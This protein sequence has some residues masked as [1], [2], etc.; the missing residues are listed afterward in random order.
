MSTDICVYVIGSNK[1][2]SAITNAHDGV[3]FSL[4]AKPDGSLVTGG[5]KDYLLKTWDLSAKES[6]STVE[7][8]I[9][10][11]LSPLVHTVY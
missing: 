3:I 8:G 4:L 6:S 2:S 10:V 1:I 5:G 9:S 11:E 7:V